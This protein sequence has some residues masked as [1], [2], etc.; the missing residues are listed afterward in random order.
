M[1]HHY[2]RGIKRRQGEKLVRMNLHVSEEVLEQVRALSQAHKVSQGTVGERI[3]SR[4]LKK[5]Q[6][7]KPA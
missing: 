5:H 2:V 6:G 4:W 1:P 7:P 3:V